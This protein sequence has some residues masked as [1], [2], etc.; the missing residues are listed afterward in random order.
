MTTMLMIAILFSLCASSCASPADWPPAPAFERPAQ[1]VGA[2]PDS[3]SVSPEGSGQWSVTFALNSRIDA[4]SVSVAGSFNGWDASALP[5]QR[6]S[7]GRWRAE[8]ELEDGLHLYKFVVNGSRWIQDPDN[9][10]SEADG[11]GGE[12]S[13]LGLGGA[14]LIAQDPGAPVDGASRLSA[15]RHQPETQM[16]RQRLGAERALLRYRTAPGESRAPQVQ[17]E[18]M[19]EAIPMRLAGEIGGFELFEAE[20]P[21]PENAT[22]YT[23]L[24]NVDGEWA[25]DPG[26]FTL[27]A[28]QLSAFV[29][30]DWAKHATWYQIMPDRFRN[31][32]PSNDPE[33]VRDWKSDW[34]EPCEHE[35]DSDLGLWE[36]WIYKRLY[37]GDLAGVLEKLDYLQSLGITALY[38]N[39]VFEAETHHKYDATDYRHI[40]TQLGKGESWQETSAAED[41]LDPTTWTW[42]ASDKLFLEL[43]KACHARDIKVVIDGVWNHV[44]QRHPAFADV[45]KNGAASPYRDWFDIVSYE[46]FEHRGWAG[47]SEL[48]V[49]KKDAGGFACQAVKDHVFAVT[50][51]WMDP[52]GDGDPSDGIDGWR[53]DV[54]MEIPMPFW[55]DWRVLVKSINPDAYLSGEVW[56][57]ADVWLNGT[58]FDAVMNYQFADAAIRWIGYKQRKISVGEFDRRLAELR[59]A[60]P[61]E[62]TQAMMNLMSSHDTDRLVSMLLNPDRTYD[63][64]NREQSNKNYDNRKPD[65]VH[66]KRARLIALLQMTYVGAPMIYYGDEVG[67]WGPD[68]PSNRKPMLWQ[69]LGEYEGRGN[70]VHEEQLAHYR[71][72]GALRRAYPA[73]R[74]GSFRTL[75]TDDEADLIVFLRED[76]DSQVLVALNAAEKTARF[77]LP[78]G[79]DWKLVFGAAK[80]SSAGGGSRAKVPAISG[81]VWV[82]PR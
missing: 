13:I 17:F 55:D 62:A 76:E 35:K 72:V 26:E 58:R 5:M 80:A 52:D 42:S 51:R 33:L 48:P 29:T 36:W 8:L 50:R 67:M 10:A 82:R 81:L 28:T 22:R 56:D 43:I 19:A 18:G 63:A 46:P 73:L 39:P 25:S 2:L 15:Y 21:L 14:A 38:F 32:D 6:G 57:R 79:K 7:D 20:V 54:P 59:L 23:F 60:Y 45:K 24:V 78:D 71:R 27:D 41:L 69:D 68:D 4:K 44:G 47:Y 11:H 40:D 49:F 37:G 12:N 64:E 66:Y 74:T 75:L 53:L 30:P 65:A 77:E 1:V 3:I 34:Y 9:S 70:E 61:I 16:Y 31:G